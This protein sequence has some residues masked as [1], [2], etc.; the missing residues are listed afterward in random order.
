MSTKLSSLVFVP[1]LNTQVRK[2]FVN[3]LLHRLFLND[4]VVRR[5]RILWYLCFLRNSIRFVRQTYPTL[6]K[7]EIKMITLY[8]GQLDPDP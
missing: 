5:S 6:L 2:V 1:S 3:H 4:K 7:T 8:Q